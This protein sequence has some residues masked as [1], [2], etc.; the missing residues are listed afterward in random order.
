MNFDKLKTPAQETSDETPEAKAAR[1]AGD[2][3]LA[4]LEGEQTAV[5]ET[6]AELSVVVENK[7]AEDAA[8]YD[9]KLAELQ[10]GAALEANQENTSEAVSS[11]LKEMSSAGYYKDRFAAL[12]PGEVPSSEF[13][14]RLIASLV[15]DRGIYIDD[16][17]KKAAEL[18]KALPYDADFVAP[19]IQKTRENYPDEE[20]K[21]K[22]SGI[23]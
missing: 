7:A 16:P 20:E 4:P 13:A 8:A 22:V 14:N 10:G 11:I 9:A 2:L 12:Q 6:S 21:M 5:T 18:M 15:S 3:E 1:M 17:Y 23:V 19:Y